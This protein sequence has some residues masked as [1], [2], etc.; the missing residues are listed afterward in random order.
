MD[1]F[2][3]FNLIGSLFKYYTSSY[4]AENGAK[5][6]EFAPV[7]SAEKDKKKETPSEKKAVYPPND[8]LYTTMK[9]HDDFVKRVSEK[10]NPTKTKSQG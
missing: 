10:S 5:K 4:T 2:G 1:K 3:I 7:F 9:S 8:A 6:S